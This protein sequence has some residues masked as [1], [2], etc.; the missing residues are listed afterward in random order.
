[1]LS[2]SKNGKNLK[3]EII[4]CGMDFD[5]KTQEHSLPFLEVLALFNFLNLFRDLQNIAT[6][7]NEL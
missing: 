2:T 7:Q 4:T 3:K 5:N 1:M 6:L